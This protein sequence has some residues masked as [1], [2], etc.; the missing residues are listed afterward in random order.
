MILEVA[1]LNVR[2]GLTE[3]FELAFM[4]A[5]SIIASIPGYRQHEVRRCLESMNMAGR[6][7]H[8]D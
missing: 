7:I 1:A 8:D 2:E 5:Q 3:E 4:K 6:A